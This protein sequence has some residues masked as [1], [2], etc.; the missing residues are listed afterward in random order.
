MFAGIFPWAATIYAERAGD[1]CRGIAQQATR[2]TTTET[3]FSFL[4][5]TFLPRT[6]RNSSAQDGDIEGR[7]HVTLIL[8]GPVVGRS[9]F[10]DR[11]DYDYDAALS[12]HAPEERSS[13]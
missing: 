8:L 7:S 1:V 9:S 13:G 3:N 12:S 5:P 4:T 2:P 6:D 10:R 11:L